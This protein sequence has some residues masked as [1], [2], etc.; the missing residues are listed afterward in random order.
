[1]EEVFVQRGNKLFGDNFIASVREG[2]YVIRP[3]GLSAGAMFETTIDGKITISQNSRVT[4]D[5]RELEEIT[6]LLKEGAKYLKDL[7]DGRIVLPKQDVISPKDYVYGGIY[8]TKMGHLFLWLGDGDV[9]GRCDVFSQTRAKYR[10]IDLSNPRSIR[11][12]G[13]L[14]LLEGYL[15]SRETKIKGF[16][17]LIGAI[18][19]ECR[20]FLLDRGGID[21]FFFHEKGS[22]AAYFN[23]YVNRYK[24]SDGSKVLFMEMD[25][26]DKKD[27]E[28][29]KKEGIFPL[30]DWNVSKE[31][32]EEMER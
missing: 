18:P 10:A 28:R 4:Y 3:Y 19:N 12:D 16:T 13:S 22:E 31:T 30:K 26:M 17:K 27:A 6:S 15:I 32:N 2:K 5:V 9:Y 7:E 11:H 29:L 21:R 1:M 23:K 25:E 24:H 8:E 14:C 20:F